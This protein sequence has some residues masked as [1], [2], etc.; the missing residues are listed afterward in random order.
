MMDESR[1]IRVY[2]LPTCGRCKTLK[3]LME[4]YGVDFQYY[5]VI[6]CDDVEYPILKISETHDDYTMYYGKEAFRY[7]RARW[8]KKGNKH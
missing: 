3:K 2:G 7:V 8:G 6:G 5:E 1:K 4:K